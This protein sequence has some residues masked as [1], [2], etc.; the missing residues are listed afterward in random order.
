VI[1]PKKYELVFERGLGLPVLYFYR[2]Y[3]T[4][5]EKEKGTGDPVPYCV[6]PDWIRT[7]TPRKAQALNL[8]RMPIPP[9]GLGRYYT[10]PTSLVNFVAANTGLRYF[11]GEFLE[12]F[13][14]SAQSLR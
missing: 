13:S 10:L 1:S 3:I 4:F 5:L 2:K 8:L 11:C 6:A 7:S 9:P 12:R 14:A